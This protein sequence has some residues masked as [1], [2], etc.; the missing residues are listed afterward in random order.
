[1]FTKI[2]D[3]LLDPIEAIL[4]K[5]FKINTNEFFGYILGILTVYLL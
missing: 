5:P 2:I 4:L 3:K 1:M